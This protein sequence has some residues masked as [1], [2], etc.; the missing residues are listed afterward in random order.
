MDD[1]RNPAC[2]I[3]SKSAE[4]QRRQRKKMDDRAVRFLA[5][6]PQHNQAAAQVNE[7]VQNA[8][9]KPLIEKPSEAR[10]QAGSS[11]TAFFPSR[12]R[13]Y[14]Q[15]CLSLSLR[16]SQDPSKNWRVGSSMP[17]VL[18]VARTGVHSSAQEFRVLNKQPLQESTVQVEIPNEELSGSEKRYDG[19][20]L[21]KESFPSRSRRNALSR[22]ECLNGRRRPL[23]GCTNDL[24]QPQHDDA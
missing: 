11:S 17:S 8:S 3:H 6:R 23:L 4:E 2:C 14:H 12:S 5:K 10:L 19:C 9:P 20:V 15:Y 21:C 16:L 7:G 1:R 24:N 13:C 18:P 22:I